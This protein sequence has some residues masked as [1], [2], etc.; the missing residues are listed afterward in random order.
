MTAE[1][2]LKEFILTKYKSVRE[3]TMETGIPYST[4][5]TILKRGIPNSGVTNIIRICKALDISADEL[6]KG[7]IVPLPL[8]GS[9]DKMISFQTFIERT[10]ADLSN[11]YIMKQNEQHRLTDE[12][13]KRIQKYI[14]A[15]C[16]A[17][18]TEGDQ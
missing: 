6:A 1:E 7:N 17:E 8:D 9:D 12:Q 10:K 2:R 16:K 3:F 11:V 14:D 13:I 5:A 4:M 15:I 18:S